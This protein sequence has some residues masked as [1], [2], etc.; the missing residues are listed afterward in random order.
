MWEPAVPPDSAA[1]DVRQY[2]TTEALFLF[3]A[4]LYATISP[5]FIS[6]LLTLDILSQIRFRPFYF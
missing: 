1:I 4:S 2:S 5:L 3:A 6:L